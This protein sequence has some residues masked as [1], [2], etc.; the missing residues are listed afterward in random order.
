MQKVKLDP[1]DIKILSELQKDGKITNIALSKAAG[2][3]A[4]PCLRRVKALE[5]AGIISGYSAELNAKE[6]GYAMQS[7][8]FVELTKQ[9]DS[10]LENF[11]IYIQDFDEIREC[12]LI[13]GKSDFILKCIAKDW[14]SFH[15]FV[16]DKLV[17][18]PNV[19]TVRT[20]P[21]IQTFKKLPMV[22]I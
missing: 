18:A 8:A 17:K 11:R 10:D 12:Y 7:M 14:D 15:S 22:P 9:S 3:S 5:D 4:P 1:V 2:I 6:L 19:K 16:T 13:S 21:I 20:A